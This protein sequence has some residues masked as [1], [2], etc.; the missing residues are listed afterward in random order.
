MTYG[1]SGIRSAGRPGA[2]EQKPKAFP[3]WC[4]LSITIIDMIAKGSYVI[5]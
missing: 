5:G 1:S 2:E 4:N 3:E